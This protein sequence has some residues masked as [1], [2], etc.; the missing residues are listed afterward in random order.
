MLLG[1]SIEVDQHVDSILVYRCTVCPV[2]CAR[3][4]NKNVISIGFDFDGSIKNSENYKTGSTG[5]HISYTQINVLNVSAG[6]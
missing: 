6:L 5:K 2:W 1:R 4:T 3:H